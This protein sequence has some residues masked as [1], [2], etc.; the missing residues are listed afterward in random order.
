MGELIVTKSGLKIRMEEPSEVQVKKNN[1]LEQKKEAE[2]NLYCIKKSL[3]EITIQE[4]KERIRIKH[5]R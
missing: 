1:L 2:F 4:D 5:Q 3:Q